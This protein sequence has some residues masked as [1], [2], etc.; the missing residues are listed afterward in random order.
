MT[1]KIRMVLRKLPRGYAWFVGGR[2]F[3]K[4]YKTQAQARAAKAYYI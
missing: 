3:G 1:K 2:Q 4:T